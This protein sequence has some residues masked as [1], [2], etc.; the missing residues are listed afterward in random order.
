MTTEMEQHNRLL[1]LLQPAS[2]IDLGF[3]EYEENKGEYP[4]GMNE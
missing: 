3:D 1:I 4:K 2:G